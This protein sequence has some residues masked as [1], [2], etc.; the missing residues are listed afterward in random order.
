[1]GGAGRMTQA[2]PHSGGGPLYAQ[3]RT[4]MVAAIVEGRWQPGDAL[5]SENQLAAEYGVSQGTL[6]KALDALAADNLVVRHQG[7][8][9]FVA[10]HTPQRELFHFFHIAGDDGSRQLP[11]TSRLVTCE[12]RRGTAGECGR[13]AL[14]AGARVVHLQRVR[15]LDGRPV[16][17]E[18]IVVP[19]R[20]F[21]GLGDGDIPNELY[22]LYEEGF[23]VTI[24]RAVEQ[25][26]AVAAGSTEARHLG[27][28]VKSPLLEVDRLAE[29]LDGTPVEWRTSRL[30]SDDHH[31]VSEI[32]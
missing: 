14:P 22:Q 8:G 1:M 31:Y 28:A 9:T 6:R 19:A 20:L 13:L 32:V 27:V 16:I 30:S 23:G 4:L 17:L 11:A 3:V 29:T 25:L 18:N 21:P 12:R 5:P 10:A 15:D 26:R 2:V 24:H 7:R